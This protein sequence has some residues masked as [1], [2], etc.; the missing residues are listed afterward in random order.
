MQH[1]VATPS[2]DQASYSETYPRIVN[3]VT[4]V[5]I[6]Q[7]QLGQ[8]VGSSLRTVQ[9]W[10]GGDT[11]PNGVKLQRL[12]DLKFLV[13]ELQTA[14]TEEGISIWLNSRNRNLSGQRPIDLLVAGNIDEVLAEAQRVSGAM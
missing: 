1:Q 3:L 8:A 11:A 2:D 13:E 12:L 4:E 9:N 7:G 5:G 6:T 14:Y 10:A